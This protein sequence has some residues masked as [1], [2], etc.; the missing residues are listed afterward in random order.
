PRR[1]ARLCLSRRPA[2]R[3]RTGAVAG[4]PA[5]RH[6]GVLAAG[7]ADPGRNQRDLAEPALVGGP[8]EQPGTGP[9]TLRATGQDPHGP[10]LR[11]RNARCH[12]RRQ[13]PGD[14]RLGLDPG[15]P[16]RLRFHGDRHGNTEQSDEIA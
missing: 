16:Q 9:D 1:P 8:G 5:N 14:H 11:P 15:H 10:D 6:G 7:K 2:H 12:G 13:H 4:T 3:H